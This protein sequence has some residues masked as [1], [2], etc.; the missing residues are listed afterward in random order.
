MGG[1]IARKELKG[2]EMSGWRSRMSRR[3]RRETTIFS[4]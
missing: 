3:L 2:R 1:S 4:W